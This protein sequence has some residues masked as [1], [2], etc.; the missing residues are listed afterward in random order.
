MLYMFTQYM[1]YFSISSVSPELHS[2]FH[3]ATVRILLSLWCAPLAYT[4]E[5][6]KIF[7]KQNYSNTFYING[8]IFYI[9]VIHIVSQQ[10]YNLQK[11]DKIENKLGDSM[12]AR[13]LKSWIRQGVRKKRTEFVILQECIYA[14]SKISRKIT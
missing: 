2:I 14:L 10:W 3:G 9:N 4:K 5:N 1:Y 8:I 6:Y 13:Y 11:K 7:K 12:R